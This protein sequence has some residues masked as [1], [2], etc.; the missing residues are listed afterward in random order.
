MTGVLIK[1]AVLDTDLVMQR[2]CEES[3]GRTP[4]EM[5]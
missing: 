3:P 4:V 2:L 5:E 1:T